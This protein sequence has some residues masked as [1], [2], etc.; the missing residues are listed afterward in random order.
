[1]ALSQNAWAKD[2]TFIELS[3]DKNKQYKLLG[4]DELITFNFIVDFN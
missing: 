3:I 1:V 2:R 4:P